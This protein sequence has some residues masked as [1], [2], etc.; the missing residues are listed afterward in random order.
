VR[1]NSR[2]QQTQAETI[3]S[4]YPPFRLGCWEADDATLLACCPINMCGA[5][6]RTTPPLQVVETM[7]M[8]P[9]LDTQVPNDNGRFKGM[10]RILDN[11]THACR[12]HGRLSTLNQI[13]VHCSR[14]M[15]TQPWNAGVAQKLSMQVSLIGFHTAEPLCCTSKIDWSTNCYHVPSTDSTSFHTFN[16]N[17]TCRVS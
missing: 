10:V 11:M 12:C 2:R 5:T 7:Q 9:W 8:N 1:G 6:A 16:A 17:S 4:Q 15:N 13:A 14:I 3:A